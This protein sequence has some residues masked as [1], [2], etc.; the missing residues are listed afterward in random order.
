MRK[1]ISLSLILVLFIGCKTTRP[2]SLRIYPTN[3]LHHYQAV[4]YIKKDIPLKV[5][6][7]YVKEKWKNHIEERTANWIIYTH[8]LRPE[9]F[10]NFE[11]Q[12][13]KEYM[14]NY[15]YKLTI[16]FRMIR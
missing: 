8:D 6:T 7:E 10:Y 15:I 12:L 13:Y 14:N 11:I 3:K 5:N 4:M 16:N 9:K 1:L 2:K